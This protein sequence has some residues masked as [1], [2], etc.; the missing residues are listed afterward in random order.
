[1]I[2]TFQ[3]INAYL[4]ELNAASI[5]LRM[6]LAV[7]CGG[8]LGVE[9]GRAHQ[10]AGMRTYMLVS[11]GACAVMLTGQYIFLTF[12]TGDPARLGAQVVSG[13]GFLGAG[14]IMVSHDAKIRGLTTAAGLWSSACIGLAI[15]I[16]FYSVGI[17]GAILILV[18][19]TRF[20]SVEFKLLL[21]T[22]WIPVYME[23]DKGTSLNEM[24]DELAKM[25]L[26]IGDMRTQEGTDCD[27]VIVYLRNEKNHSWEEIV[28]FLEKINGVHFVR[29][30]NS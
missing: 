12:Q 2:Q 24:S 25:D 26:E 13:I 7:T 11:L 8:M 4:H 27:K 29:Y 17:F 16:G 19:M 9:R 22:V 30:F 5:I 23:V 28:R 18:I 1:M 6:L 20:R 14:S 21:D 3:S 10:S 15:G